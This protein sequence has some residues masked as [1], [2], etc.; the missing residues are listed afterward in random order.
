MRTSR[1]GDQ[2]PLCHVLSGYYRMWW[3]LCMVSLILLCLYVLGRLRTRIHLLKMVASLVGWLVGWVG[4]LVVAW[5]VRLLVSRV[6]ARG[7]KRGKLRRV[8]PT[9]RLVSILVVQDNF[10]SDKAVKTCACAS[11]RNH[12]RS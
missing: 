4:G 11:Q 8:H 9:V 10:P 3:L 6:S 5:L 1:T 12:K 2:M 7:A